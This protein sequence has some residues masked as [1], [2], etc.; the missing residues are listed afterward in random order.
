MLSSMTAAQDIDEMS[1]VHL[2]FLARMQEQAF[3]SDNLRTIHKSIIEVLD[4]CV[5][6][7]E[8]CTRLSL[9][10]VPAR[11]R[12]PPAK[13][14]K[15]STSQKPK[16]KAKPSLKRRKSIIPS[17]IEAPDISDSE[18]D[19]GDAEVETPSKESPTS[20]RAQRSKNVTADLHRV[21]AEL[22]RLLPFISAGLRNIGRAGAQEVW[23]M[24][25]ERL[26]AGRPA[27]AGR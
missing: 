8:T 5:L 14:E 27:G 2:Q 26:E 25:A 11:P 24:L 21:E 12:S 13:D 15:V 23:E 16:T 19:A 18:S 1:S 22:K 20:A 4:V 17:I 7:A 6:W 9:D 10:S 3:L